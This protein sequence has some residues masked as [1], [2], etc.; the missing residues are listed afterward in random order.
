VRLTPNQQRDTRA[1]FATMD[2]SDI[3]GLVTVIYL[4][5]AEQSRFSSR[6]Q[7]KV[8]RIKVSRVS[9]I[10]PAYRVADWVFSV[11]LCLFHQPVSK[12]RLFKLNRSG[13]L[14]RITVL[15]QSHLSGDIPNRSR[16][17]T[18]DGDTG[19]ILMEFSPHAKMAVTV[20]QSQF[21]EWILS[22]FADLF[23]QFFGQWLQVFVSVFSG[24]AI[25]VKRDF[26]CGLFEADGGEVAFMG[27]SPRG[28][29]MIVPPM[30]KQ[31]GFQLTL[32]S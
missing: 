27:L 13:T 8:A 10:V 15:H 23:F 21:Y 31:H 7:R 3:K 29:A 26:L 30:A 1:I 9:L 12:I 11:L 22:P 6:D 4:F 2:H 32:V 25:I 14:S 28:F 18:C 24:L 17:L 5:F 20:G 16:Q 19:L